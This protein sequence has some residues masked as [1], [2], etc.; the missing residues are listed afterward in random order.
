MISGGNFSEVIFQRLVFGVLS[1]PIMEAEYG[2]ISGWRYFSGIFMIQFYTG[3]SNL[4]SFPL[5]G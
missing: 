5:L 3:S 1:A 4:Y 2:F